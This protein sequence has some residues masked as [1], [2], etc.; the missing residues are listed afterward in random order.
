[1]DDKKV[2]AFNDFVDKL[3]EECCGLNEEQ[4]ALNRAMS[5]TSELKFTVS[6]LMDIAIALTHY[7]CSRK[8]TNELGDYGVLELKELL[9]RIN[10]EITLKLN[11]Q[12][13]EVL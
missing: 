12:G 4:K 11:E 8:S 13:I 6:E 2:K 7:V 5:A 10:E 9:D 1:M 3:L